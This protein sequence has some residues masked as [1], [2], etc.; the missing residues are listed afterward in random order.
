M[1]TYVGNN[2]KPIMPQQFVIGA[3][4][5]EMWSQELRVT[6]PLDEPVHATAGR[7]HGAPDAQHLA[8]LHHAGLRLDQHLWRQPERLRLH[9]SQRL[10]GSRISEHHLAHRRAAR[11]SRPRGVRAGDLGH[12]Q[13]VVADGR[14][15]LLQIRQF[16]ARVLRVSTRPSPRARAWPP[17]SSRWSIV[18]N[19]PCTD[20]DARTSRHRLGA[21]GQPSATR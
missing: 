10:L 15:A 16:A 7:I 4:D 17:A 21:Q 5:F 12:Q 11:R 2:G 18:K 1:P 20:L 3:G 9:R 6:T 8:E 14:R 19:S 13:P